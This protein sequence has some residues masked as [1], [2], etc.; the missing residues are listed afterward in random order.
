MSETAGS[1]LRP[2]PVDRFS[3]E[4]HYFDLRQAAAQLQD[5]AHP[6]QE[7]HRQI[8]LYHYGSVTVVLFVFEAGSKLPEHIAEGLETIHALEGDL[9]VRAQGQSYELSAESLLVINPGVSRS[10][11]ARSAARM[12]LTVHLGG[13]KTLDSPRRPEA[14]Q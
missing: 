2:H 8:A 6:P 9:T 10:I 7:G 1:R 5:E 13:E 12:L 3:A 4:E 14:T 11:E